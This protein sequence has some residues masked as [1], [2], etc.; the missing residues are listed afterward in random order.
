MVTLTTF[1]AVLKDIYEAMTRSQLNLTTGALASAIEQTARNIEGGRKVVKPAPYGVNGGTGS[2]S[3]SGTLPAAGGNMYVDFTS[4]LKNLAGVIK[5]TD[6]VMEASK[7]SRA[8]FEN[9]FESEMDGLMKGAKH[10]Y[11]RQIYMDGTGNLTA[12][13]TTADSVTVSV[14]STQYLI[15]GMTIDILLTATG[16]AITN[17]SARRISAVD[18]SA[19]TIVLSGADKV[20]TSS[21]NHIVEQGSLNNELTGLEAVYAQT[22]DLYGLSKTTYP[23][24]KP[25]V[26]PNAG[27]ISDQLIIDV[28]NY[29]EEYYGSK[30]NMIHCNPNVHSEYYAYLESTKRSPN[31]LDLKGGFKAISIN[32]IPLVKD[33]Y[34]KSG[35]MKLND[36]TQFKMHVLKDWSWMNKDGAILKWVSNYAA[37][38]AILLKYAELICDHPGGQAEISGITTT[39]TLFK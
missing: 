15:E 16:A 34:V 23:W 2:F 36:T 12:C 33:R 27:A 35:V 32:G 17:G 22:G 8:A 3:E 39:S 38:T 20:T 25:Y 14:A 30:I 24:L 26:H 10:T 31:T 1:D 37:Y 18:R 7:S 9:A 19:N 13:G 6:K 21:A 5:F 11:G 28:I 4:Y 29:V